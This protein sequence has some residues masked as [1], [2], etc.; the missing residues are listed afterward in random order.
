MVGV[1]CDTTDKGPDIR[2][3]NTILWSLVLA[4]GLTILLAERVTAATCF[5]LHR[6]LEAP[7]SELCNGITAHLPQRIVVTR[8]GSFDKCIK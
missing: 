1:A 3:V 4:V 2:R 6:V 5:G 7:A 8:L